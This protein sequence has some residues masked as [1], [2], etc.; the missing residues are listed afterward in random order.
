MLWLLAKVI[1]FLAAIVALTFAGVRLAELG[2]IFRIWAFDYEFT[3]T[4]LAAVIA[5]VV[6]LIIVWLVIALLGL[7]VAFFRFLNGDETA[8]S[9]FF[10]RNREKRGYTALSEGM[11]ALASGDAK[12]AL[13]RAR[14][15]AKLLN[16]PE[17]TTLLTAQ[18][19]EAAGD[20]EA[21]AE[22]WKSLLSNEAT[23]FV[24]V[25][26]LLQQKLSQGDTET[27]LKLA[28]QAFILRPRS[29]ETQDI[30]L[31][32]Q[33]DNGDWKGARET[34]LEKQKSGELPKS[35]WRRR[36]A[37]LMLQQAKS[38]LAAGNNDEARETAIAANR[39]SPDLVPAAVIAS[40]ACIDK[41][42]SK[43]AVRILKKA[44]I[45]APHPD[46][47]AAFAE[48]VPD[49]SPAARLH[50]FRPL[51][52]EHPEHEET[53]LMHAELLLAAD[54]PSAAKAVLGD[55][56][57]KH[58]T[59]RSL[60][61]LAAAERGCGTDDTRVR[62]ILARALTAAPGPAWRC[63]KCDTTHDQWRPICPNC[64]GFD[65]LSWR[66]PGPKDAASSQRLGRIDPDLASKIFGR[67]AQPIQLPV[68]EATTIPEDDHPEAD[69]DE[70]R[71]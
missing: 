65:T 41:G 20:H 45:A 52:S 10:D 62:D 8:I 6:L 28:R 24:A 47:A 54:D 51:L 60:A 53:R 38:A 23:R 17:F 30:L 5:L 57:D 39:L 68:E 2:G 11:V 14:K 31:G 26:G 58:P 66:D 64:H 48:I 44:W 34:L 32:L 7:L 27:A 13:I 33:A 46:L 3:L 69:S 22:A 1:L 42:D 12:Q 15:A 40:R 35:V 4:P 56:P 49:E 67:S 55:I 70:S 59:R 71:S 37:L 29:S 16:K 18:A 43:G 36:D 19:A 50:R 21:A 25:R 63:D 61:L 9:R